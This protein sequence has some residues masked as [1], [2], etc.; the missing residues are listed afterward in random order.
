MGTKGTKVTQIH[1]MNVLCY[2]N[3]IK[4]KYLKANQ[5]IKCKNHY[6]NK[7]KQ[8][9]SD[10]TKKISTQYYKT[11]ILEYKIKSQTM[12]LTF[13]KLT[14]TWMDSKQQHTHSDTFS[15]LSSASFLDNQSC[16]EQHGETANNNCFSMVTATNLFYKKGKSNIGSFIYSTEFCI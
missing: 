12:A 10:H 3:K 13:L 16:S 1:P 5:E 8:K 2:D 7:T 15:Q 14:H 11:F 6:F 9:T 4:V